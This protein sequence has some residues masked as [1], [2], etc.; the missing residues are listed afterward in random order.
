MSV[1]QRDYSE[2]EQVLTRK[3]N[4]INEMSVNLTKM[5]HFTIGAGVVFFVFGI[6][7]RLIPMQKLY[8][9]SWIEFIAVMILSAALLT[10]GASTMLAMYFKT[11][12]ALE[13]IGP[14]H[15]R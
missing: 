13:R 2:T 14:T 10:A 5:S 7:F 9:L 15:R 1:D 12:G 3:I 8:N 4:A 6:V 11:V